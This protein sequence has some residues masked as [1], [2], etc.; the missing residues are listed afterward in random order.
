MLG[1]TSSAADR[2]LG[3]PMFQVLSR[4]KAKEQEG[5]DIIHFEI[6]DPDFDTPKNI[7]DAACEALRRGETHYADSMGLYEFRKLICENNLK[8]RGFKPDINQVLIAPGANILIYYAVACLVNQGEEVILPDPSFSTY[9][10]VL[11]LC[12][13]KGVP[14]PLKKENGFRLQPDDVRRHITDKTKL[15]IVNSPHNP[16]GAVMTAEELTGIAEIAIENGIYLYSD[17]IYSRMNYGE[18]PFFSPSMIDNCKTNVIVANGFSKAF[19]MTGWRLGTCVGPQ[20]V[21][22]KMALLLETTSSCVSPFIQRA[23]MEA[24]QGSQDSVLEMVRKYHRRR[25]LLVAGLNSI[26]RIHCL[27]PEG[28]FYVFPDIRQT[29]LTSKMFAQKALDI[30]GV[31]LLPGSDFGPSGEGFVRLCYATSEE[32]IEKGIDRLKRMVRTI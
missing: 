25:D 30:A 6:G 19:A 1:Y 22:E 7:V 24:I 2:L 9:N 29:G 8:T 4:I 31:G 10:S 28:A 3:Q 14:I 17:E 20:A 18:I 16:T 32:N 21:I 27:L 26:P 5:Y 11:N 12:G 13:A 23:G 15:I